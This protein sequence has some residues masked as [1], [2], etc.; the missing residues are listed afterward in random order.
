MIEFKVLIHSEIGGYIY[1]TIFQANKV[2]PFTTTIRI[3]NDNIN[4]SITNKYN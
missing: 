2:Q 1:N 3:K 4:V